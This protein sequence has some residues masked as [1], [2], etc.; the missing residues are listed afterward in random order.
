MDKKIVEVVVSS[1]F[2]ERV[3]GA[4]SLHNADVHRELNMQEAT[5]IWGCRVEWYEAYF[6]TMVDGNRPALVPLVTNQAHNASPVGLDDL[7]DEYSSPSSSRI[8]LDDL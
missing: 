3:V 6:E 1:N 7:Q 8:G 5:M 2:S 4:S